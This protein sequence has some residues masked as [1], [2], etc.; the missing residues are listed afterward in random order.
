MQKKKR[1]HVMLW[2]F[3]SRS[4]FF[5]IPAAL[6]LVLANEVRGKDPL[7]GDVGILTAINTY[8]S[9]WL[10]QTFLV[11][12]SLGSA[13][14]VAIAIAIATATMWYIGRKTDALFLLF[15]AGGTAAI[16]ITI[17]LLFERSR[18][19]VFEHLILENGYSFPS[20]HAMISMSLA[21]AV[22]ILAWRTRYRWTAVI[23]GTLYA[24]LVGF[25][26][27]YLGVHY[28]SDVL[29]GWCISILWTLTLYHVLA[30]FS[31]KHKIPFF[32]K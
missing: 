29:A 4:V 19:N 15:A 22:V 25:S 11:I 27:L 20:G 21:L 31:A 9:D 8:H 7:P 28:P 12:T 10:T 13:L 24:L 5:W 23:T 30:R 18:P 32:S 2:Q 16:N 6:F 3:I 1:F 17:K 26:R 14:F